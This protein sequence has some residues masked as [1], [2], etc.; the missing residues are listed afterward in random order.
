M[1]NADL[2]ERIAE[3]AGVPKSTAKSI[4]DSMFEQI[5]DASSR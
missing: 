5:R 4:V 1:N 2:A 3:E